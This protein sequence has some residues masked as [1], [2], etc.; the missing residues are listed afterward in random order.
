MAIYSKLVKWYYGNRRKL[1]W[2]GDPPPYGEKGG[3]EGEG[4]GK[5]SPT[6]AVL[7]WLIF[8]LVAFGYDV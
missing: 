5:R 2:R 7:F 8:K 3:R 4:E 6:P 1:P